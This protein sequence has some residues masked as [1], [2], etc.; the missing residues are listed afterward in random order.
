MNILAD[1]GFVTEILE[2]GPV[3]SRQSQREFLARYEGLLERCMLVIL[4]GSLPVGVDTNMYQRLV[5]GARE[6]GVPVYLDSSGESMRLGM[7]AKPQQIHQ[8]GIEKVVV[9]MGSKGLVSVSDEGVYYARAEHI[10]AVN[11]V[12]CGD[13]VVASYAMSYWLEESDKDALLR[14]CAIS[15]ANATT[16]ESASIPKQTAEELMK[17]IQV[18]ALA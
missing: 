17:A 6:A 12:A 5:I 11:T 1:D 7:E 13:S 2:P 14:A 15:A 8:E 9:S 10:K 18:E 16:R 4:S 3:V